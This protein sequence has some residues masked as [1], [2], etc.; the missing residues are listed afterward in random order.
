M[1]LF[2]AAWDKAFSPHHL[3][4]GKEIL[5]DLRAILVKNRMIRG[6]NVQTY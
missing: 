4:G 1:Y 3:S 5:I 2:Y 6:R